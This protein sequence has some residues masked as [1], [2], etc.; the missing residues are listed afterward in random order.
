MP[1]WRGRR[2]GYC[3]LPV[4]VP[5]MQCH[6]H[7]YGLGLS[8]SFA[9]AAAARHHFQTLD[10]L[11][12]RFVEDSVGEEDQ[13]IRAGVGWWSSL[14]SLGRNTLDSLASTVSSP[15]CGPVPGCYQHLRGHSFIR[16]PHSSSLVLKINNLDS[17]YF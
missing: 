10:F 13:P 3:D 7:S 11:A 1:R 16:R 4:V 9:S 5:L 17:I 2:V 14:A 6:P 12:H 8:A 15:F